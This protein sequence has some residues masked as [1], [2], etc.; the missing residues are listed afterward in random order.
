MVAEAVKKVCVLAIKMSFVGV[1]FN[2]ETITIEVT[3]KCLN[4]IKL[5]LREKSIF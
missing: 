2:S 1:L 5:L 4:E 3:E